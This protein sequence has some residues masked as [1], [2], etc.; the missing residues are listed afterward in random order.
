MPSPSKVL[1]S[2]CKQLSPSVYLAEPRQQNVIHEVA[3]EDGRA[4]DYELETLDK[5][6]QALSATGRASTMASPAPKLI[7]LV[8]WMSANPTHISKY[9]VGY[10]NLYPNS[11]V[12][13]VQSSPPD[14]FYRRTSTQRRRVA[15]AISKIPVP[16]STD[17]QNPQIILHTFSNGGCHQTRNL[18]LAYRESTSNPFPPHIM[19]FDSCPGRS[20]FKR[21]VLALSAALPTFAPARYLLL[22]LIYI[23]VGIY[24]VIFIPFGIPDPIQHLRTATVDRYLMRGETKRCY[25][26][27]EADSMVGWEDVE[28]HARSAADAGFVVRR[29]KFEESGHCAHMRVGGGLRYWSIVDTLWQ[30]KQG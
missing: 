12:L 28:A 16:S 1:L 20:T 30:E 29:E 3:G 11:R 5:M 18:L 13:V 10:Q 4:P 15:P 21:T 23:I 17:S 19:I 9:I 6:E 14:L 24:W 27:S 2:T 26:Y 25:I 7:I 22:A 8:T